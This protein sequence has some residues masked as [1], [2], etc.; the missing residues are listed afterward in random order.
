MNPA[1]DPFDPMAQRQPPPFQ[2][3]GDPSLFGNRYASQGSPGRYYMGGNLGQSAPGSKSPTGNPVDPKSQFGFQGDYNQW[4]GAMAQENPWMEDTSVQWGGGPSGYLPIGY[5][6][7]PYSHYQASA[8]GNVAQG[9][10][11]QAAN[12]RWRPSGGYAQLAPWEQKYAQDTWTQ[13]YDPQQ[14]GY[15]NTRNT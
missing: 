10:W 6:A 11:A 3:S 13:N 9:P 8:G 7:Q 4:R 12:G 14:P 1:Y 5:Q 2:P 15:I